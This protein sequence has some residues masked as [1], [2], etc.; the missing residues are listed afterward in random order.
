MVTDDEIYNFRLKVPP[1]KVHCSAHVLNTFLSIAST[2][3]LEKNSAA[4]CDSSRSL[5]NFTFPPP[6]PPVARHC[7]PSGRKRRCGREVTQLTLG[8]FTRATPLREFSFFAPNQP[9]A[10]K[11]IS[12]TSSL[13]QLPIVS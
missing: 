12:T 1:P 13:L 3:P 6:F 7:G 11:R 2:S 10:T 5:R 8:D 9:S 4:G